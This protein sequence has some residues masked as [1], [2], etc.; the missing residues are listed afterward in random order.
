[1]L[2]KTPFLRLIT[3]TFETK[4]IEGILYAR[5]FFEN[6]T[7]HLNLIKYNSKYLKSGVYY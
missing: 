7:F 6:V 5:S 3:L 1:M 4:K 2:F